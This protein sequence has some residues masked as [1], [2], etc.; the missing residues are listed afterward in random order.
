MC[1][2]R[3]VVGSE[4]GTDAVGGKFDRKGSF[5]QNGSR[6]TIFPAGVVV[7]MVVNHVLL[8]YYLPHRYLYS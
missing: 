8:A 4:G 7:V 3:L 2:M 5:Y 1:C 6:S